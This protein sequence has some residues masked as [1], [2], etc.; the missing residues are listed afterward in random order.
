M[1]YSRRDD[2]SGGRSG[3][4]DRGGFHGRGR[5]SGRPEMHRATCSDC[6]NSCEVPF[7]PTG[8]KPVYCSNCFEG[9]EGGG[10]RSPRFDRRDSGGRDSGRRD[11]GGRDSG[12]R[13]MHKA[14][15]G[16]CGDS[17]E[18]P[19]KPTQGKEVLCSPCFSKDGP[20]SSFSSSSRS[21]SGGGQDMSKQFD[22]LSRKLDLIMKTLG[23][24]TPAPKKFAKSDKFGKSA[25]SNKYKAKKEKSA[26]VSDSDFE[27]IDI[28]EEVEVAKPKKKAVKAKAKSKA[29]VKKVA[30]PKAKKKAPAKKKA[31]KVKV[32]KKK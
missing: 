30:K 25:K 12:N 29:K 14:T 31:A 18:V 7:K 6:G 32:K 9:K 11:F 20:S 21:H 15:C 8:R 4:G 5:D 13:G 16:K 22:A 19:F 23:V 28:G 26:P 24:E 17:C 3:G 2:R 1:A 10:S 27:P